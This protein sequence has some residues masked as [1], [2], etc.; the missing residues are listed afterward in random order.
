M[1]LVG[2]LSLVT[3]SNPLVHADAFAMIRKRKMNIFSIKLKRKGSVTTNSLLPFMASD[4]K[5]CSCTAKEMI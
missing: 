1:L 3:Y 5:K 2:L 4:Q